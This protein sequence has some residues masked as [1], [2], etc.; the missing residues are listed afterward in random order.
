MENRRRKHPHLV[1]VADDDDLLRRLY[2]RLLRDRFDLVI[3]PDGR[4]AMAAASEHPPDLALLDVEMP[5]LSGFQVA[6]MLLALPNPPEI[7]MISGVFM[8]SG[9]VDHSL[10]PE[11]VR[12]CIPKPVERDRLLRL[13]DQALRD[14]QARMEGGLFAGAPVHLDEA[15]PP[16]PRSS[17][18]P[19]DSR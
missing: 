6:R 3:V 1:L 13:M 10:V 11:G 12:A 15:S 19:L 4:S 16:S 7:L 18:N 9:A 17:W 5:D 2:Q 14:R 8:K